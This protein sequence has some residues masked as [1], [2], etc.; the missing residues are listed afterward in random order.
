M[1]LENNLDR[2]M[3]EHAKD[4]RKKVEG[5]LGLFHLDGD[6][7][8][9]RLVEQFF[10]D[11]FRTANEPISNRINSIAEKPSSSNS[12]KLRRMVNKLD[13]CD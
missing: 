9:M 11:L 12:Q 4:S 2:R 1:A 3:K 10:M 6:K 8:D 7:N 13:F 5:V